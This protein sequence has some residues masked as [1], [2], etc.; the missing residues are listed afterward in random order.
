L[1]FLKTDS[2]LIFTQ[3]N[4]IKSNVENLFLKEILINN[5]RSVK[6]SSQYLKSFLNDDN[7][8]RFLGSNNINIYISKEVISRENIINISKIFISKNFKVF[9]GISLFNN[10]F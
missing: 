9:L 4:L 7:V 2:I 3:T 8:L 1:S 5:F 6:I 10:F